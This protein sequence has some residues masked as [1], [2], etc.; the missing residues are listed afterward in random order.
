[1]KKLL[2]IVIILF[3]FNQLQAQD[4]LNYEL[5]DAFRIDKKFSTEI[6]NYLIQKDELTKSE[7]DEQK[8]NVFNY[9]Y[10]IDIVNPSNLNN[11]GI[12]RFG[13]IQSHGDNYL[14]IKSKNKIEILSDYP[15]E[16]IEKKVS[17]FLNSQLKRCETDIIKK[18]KS[19]L[20]EWFEN[21]TSLS[22]EY[23]LGLSVIPAIGLGSN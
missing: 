10:A 1:M 21:R 4:T 23:K 6:L 7:I 11:I 17:D 12:Y 22:M 20:N 19:A 5:V 18:Y 13:I 9:V 15:R 8:L 2:L 16:V 3:T 14:L